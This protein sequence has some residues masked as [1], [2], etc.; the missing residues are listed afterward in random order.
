MDKIE[1]IYTITKG[2]NVM[3]I[4]KEEKMFM[5]GVSARNCSQNT[6][7]QANTISINTIK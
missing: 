2:E 6:K 4:Y 7:E 3:S 1:N 5:H